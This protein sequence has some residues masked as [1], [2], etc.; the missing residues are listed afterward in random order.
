MWEG[1]CLYGYNVALDCREGKG[2]TGCLSTHTQ[3]PN[4]WEVAVGPGAATEALLIT[5]AVIEGRFH[6]M[7]R[8]DLVHRDVVLFCQATHQVLRVAHELGWREGVEAG[9]LPPPTLCRPS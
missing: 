3:P 2:W 8:V 7:T 9:N 4:L 5:Q 6:H 1:L